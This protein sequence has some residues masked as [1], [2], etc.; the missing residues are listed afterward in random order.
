LLRTVQHLA[1]RQGEL[2]ARV[3]LRAGRLTGPDARRSAPGVPGSPLGRG[4]GNGKG[5]GA[6]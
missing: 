5:L 3:R 1:S 6:Q 4:V 2:A